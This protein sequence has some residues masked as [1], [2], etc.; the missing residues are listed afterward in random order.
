GSPESRAGCKFARREGRPAESPFSLP[1]KRLKRE[2]I[3]FQ[4]EVVLQ[5]LYLQDGVTVPLQIMHV[6]LMRSPHALVVS[7]IRVMCPAQKLLSGVVL[8]LDDGIV[9]LADPHV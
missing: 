3:V 9:V 7:D 1:A 6:D 8:D 4:K 2:C 5:L